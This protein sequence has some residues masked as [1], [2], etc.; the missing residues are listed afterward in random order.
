MIV[1]AD[2]ERIVVAVGADRIET[3]AVLPRDAEA[4]AAEE[5]A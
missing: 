4:E 5:D 2:G 1:E 3:L